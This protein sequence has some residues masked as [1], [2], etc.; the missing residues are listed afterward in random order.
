MDEAQR[1]GCPINLTLEV[2]GDKWSLLIIRDMMFG[3]RRHFR[4]LL[5]K[6]EEGI[7]SNILADRL[8]TLLDQGIITWADDPS[9]KHCMR[10][11]PTPDPSPQ[12]GG[13]NTARIIIGR[14]P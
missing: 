13:E 14:L 9:H 11:T 12:G 7:S 10:E 2:V 3:N 1:S 6:S 8:K 5:T 4:E